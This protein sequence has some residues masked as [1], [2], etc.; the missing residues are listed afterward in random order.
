MSGWVLRGLLLMA[1]AGILAAVIVILA[2]ALA[3]VLALGAIAVIVLVVLR[4][5]GTKKPQE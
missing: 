4:E 1:V 2:R 3:V 5:I